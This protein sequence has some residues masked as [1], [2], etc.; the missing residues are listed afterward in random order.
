M[1]RMMME[2]MY[3]TPEPEFKAPNNITDKETFE[4]PQQPPQ[5]PPPPPMPPF[6]RPQ[7][8]QP[9]V[10]RR[11]DIGS[12]RE[13]LAAK[14]PGYRRYLESKKNATPLKVRGDGTHKGDVVKLHMS[15][16]K[17]VFFELTL[18]D[19]RMREIDKMMMIKYGIYDDSVYDISIDK[20]ETPEV[21]E[22]KSWWGKGAKKK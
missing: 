2:P 6:V 19:D 13:Q 17:Y 10:E 9:R 5:R 18:S 7:P 12:M 3:K 20:T 11:A 15:D 22:K 8:P 1:R 4:M 14:D 21:K 16:G